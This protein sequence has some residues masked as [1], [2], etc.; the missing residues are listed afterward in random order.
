MAWIMMM[1]VPT[2]SMFLIAAITALVEYIPAN[3]S[4][5]SDTMGQKPNTV[6]IVKRPTATHPVAPVARA[7]ANVS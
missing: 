5:G 3:A 1:R 7:E 6:K 2:L 4:E